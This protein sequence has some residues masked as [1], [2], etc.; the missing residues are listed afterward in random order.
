MVKHA[1]TQKEAIKISHIIAKKPSD[2]DGF[3]NFRRTPDVLREM[4]SIKWF[5]K[6][7]QKSFA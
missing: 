4:A 1:T 5:E 2:F 3:A 7:D 6:H